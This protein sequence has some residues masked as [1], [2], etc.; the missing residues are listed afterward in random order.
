M[1]EAGWIDGP[2][3]FELVI[4]LLADH[5]HKLPE[6]ILDADADTTLM[7]FKLSGI[8]QKYATKKAR[9]HTGSKGRF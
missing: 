6:E 9:V 8:Y 7:Y 2:M 1:V 3:P 5:Y 4:A